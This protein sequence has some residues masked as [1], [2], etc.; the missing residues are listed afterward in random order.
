MRFPMT[1]NGTHGTPTPGNPLSMR[2]AAV[3]GCHK[4]STRC[5]KRPPAPTGG[6][7]PWIS[8]MAKSKTRRLARLPSSGGIG[9][10][11]RPFASRNT[12]TSRSGRHSASSCCPATRLRQSRCTT[13]QAQPSPA[14]QK[15]TQKS[16]HSHQGQRQQP[17]ATPT[18][19]E[20]DAAPN[21]RI[22]HSFCCLVVCS[23]QVADVPE[24]VESWRHVAEDVLDRA[25]PLGERRVDDRHVLSGDLLG[26][27]VELYA[28]VVV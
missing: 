22:S 12:R 10:I 25:Q 26:A 8:L 16:R 19:Q 21:H 6:I 24:R 14:H 20:P 3:P 13:Q 18:T 9:P 28:F 7:C 27:V 4:G 17:P 2:P 23:V 11:S 1:G 15:P 5:Q